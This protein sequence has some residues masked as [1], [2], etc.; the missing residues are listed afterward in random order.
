MCYFTGDELQEEQK[1]GLK[2]Q[3]F[4]MF[5]GIQDLLGLYQRKPDALSAFWSLLLAVLDT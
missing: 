4:L 1:V 2:M 5:L 3:G